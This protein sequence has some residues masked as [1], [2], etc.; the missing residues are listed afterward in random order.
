M[1]KL[2]FPLRANVFKTNDEDPIAFY[3]YPAIG[4]IYRKRLAN[5]LSL[6]SAGREKILDIGYGSGLLFPSLLQF[7]RTCYGLENH[8]QEEKVYDFL[9]KEKISREKVILKNGSV[10]AIPFADGFF[11]AVVSVSTLEHIPDL[12]KAMA[13]MSRVLSSGGEMILS[14]PVRNQVTDWFYRLFGYSPRK[15]H[16]SSHR[17]IIAAAEKYF[18][19]EKIIKFPARFPL[20]YSFYCSIKCAKK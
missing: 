4:W 19:I 6:L 13:E 1:P 11:D 15:I 3:Y 10:L 17:D 5:T 18:Q 7:G 14:F 9:A 12:D 8:G 2:I 16:P 20:D